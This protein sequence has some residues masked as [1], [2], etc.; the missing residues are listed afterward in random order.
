MMSPGASSIRQSQDA[1]PGA[2][3]TCVGLIAHQWQASGEE[4]CRRELRGYALRVGLF[5]LAN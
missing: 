5:P 2:D 3:R 4:R 1:A